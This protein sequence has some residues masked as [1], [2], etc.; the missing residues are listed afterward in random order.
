[1]MDP[2]AMRSFRF[3]DL[4]L[5]A[6]N[7]LAARCRCTGSLEGRRYDACAGSG[8]LWFDPAHDSVFDPCFC[9]FLGTARD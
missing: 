2:S 3:V 6:P 7:G 4:S 1:M 9:N 5:E 8:Q